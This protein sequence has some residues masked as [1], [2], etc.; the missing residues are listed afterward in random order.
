MFKAICDF[1]QRT[2]DALPAPVASVVDV[3]R[4]EVTFDRCSR[5]Y[6]AASITSAVYTC[7]RGNSDKNDLKEEALLLNEM[8]LHPEKLRSASPKTCEKK[9]I[10]GGRLLLRQAKSIAPP[11][12]TAKIIELYKNTV[13]ICVEK[14]FK[15]QS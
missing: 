11:E 8:A 4:S 5:V 7:W 1:V 6:T 10:I 15:K 9:Q 2:H 14:C 3:G 13:G 12:T